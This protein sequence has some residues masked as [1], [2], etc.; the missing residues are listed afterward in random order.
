MKPGTPPPDVR[1]LFYLFTFAFLQKTSEK[2]HDF[3]RGMN[4]ISQSKTRSVF[5]A[6][7][8]CSRVETPTFREY[9]N[10]SG[11]FFDKV[12]G[13]IHNPVMGKTL[14]VLSPRLERADSYWMRPISSIRAAAL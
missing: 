14:W 3:N 5:G 8:L 6:K 7:P 11:L 4:R 10:P 1:A 13:S 12:W 9:I 2:A